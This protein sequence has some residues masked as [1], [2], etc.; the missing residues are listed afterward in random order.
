MLLTAKQSYLLDQMTANQS[1]NFLWSAPQ[2]NAIEKDWKVPFIKAS[3]ALQENSFAEADALYKQSLLE[4]PDEKRLLNNLGNTAF[5]REQ[6]H[7][8]LGYYQKAIDQNPDYVVAHYNMSQVHNEMLAFEKGKGKYMEAKNISQVL[9][10][11]YAQ[12][13][14]KYP[15]HPV[16]EERFTQRDL[17]QNL[18]LLNLHGPEKPQPIRQLFIGGISLTPFLISIILLSLALYF[19]YTKLIR[20]VSGEF[21]PTCHKAI[22]VQCRES[23]THY[24]LCGECSTLMITASTQKV[25]RLP[26]RLIPF[27]IIPGGGQIVL[28][29]TALALYMLIPFY[30]AITLMVV[31]DN[32]LTSEYWHLSISGSPLLPIT[33]VFVYGIYLTD[34]YLRRKG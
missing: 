22:C 9:T 19:A 26:K 27:F 24:N 21:C 20:Y 29:K 17:W 31:G 4:N 34:L 33:V 23:F 32:F 13:A 1:G 12:S 11:Y 28:Q 7:E 16:I 10:E 2:F 25:G 3:Y 18:F 30:F 6:F 14:S 8:A 15:N 5:Y